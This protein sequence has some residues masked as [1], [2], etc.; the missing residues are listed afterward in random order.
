M[1]LKIPYIIENLFNVLEHQDKDIRGLCCWVLSNIT[2]GDSHQLKLIIGNS[3]YVSKILNIIENDTL[4]VEKFQRTSF[5]KIGEKG[6]GFS[7]FKCNKKREH[8]SDDVN[9]EYGGFKL[10]VQVDP[11]KGEKACEVR[12]SGSEGFFK[13]PGKNN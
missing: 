1:I 3:F 4:S 11:T 8:K 6:C 7:D 2:A 12:D 10:Y 13:M 5:K 9:G